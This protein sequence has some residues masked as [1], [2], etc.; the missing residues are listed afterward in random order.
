MS[1]SQTEDGYEF[2]VPEALL[3]PPPPPIED[4]SEKT[5]TPAPIKTKT[6][7]TSKKS[8]DPNKKKGKKSS[9]AKKKVS[10]IGVTVQFVVS[11]LMVAFSVL[12]L[13]MSLIAFTSS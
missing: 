1:Q 9:L 2:F 4:G 8:P 5:P 3:A 10:L 7:T 6:R 13:V 11:I 12:C